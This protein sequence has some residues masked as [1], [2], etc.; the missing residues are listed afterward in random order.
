[1]EMANIKI[2]RYPANISVEIPIEL[3]IRASLIIASFSV[4]WCLFH[5][6]AL[7]IFGKKIDSYLDW[8]IWTTWRKNRNKSIEIWNSYQKEW[9]SFIDFC[10]NNQLRIGVEWSK[11]GISIMIPL[12]IGQ[13]LD[14]D[15]II[16]NAIILTEAIMLKNAGLD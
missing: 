7:L 11:K 15:N 5:W 8:G 4:L 1:M 12:S 14:M 3:E 2:I 10:K 13:S 6:P 16:K 9:K